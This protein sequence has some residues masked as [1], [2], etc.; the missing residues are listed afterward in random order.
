MRAFRPGDEPAILTLFHR[1]FGRGSPGFQPRTLAHWRWEF[2]GAPMGRRIFVATGAG[3]VIA[4]FA[5]LRFAAVCGDADVCIELGVD[6][7]ADGLGAGL[8]RSRPFVRAARAYFADCEVAGDVHATYGFPN[9]QALRVGRALLGYRRVA[10]RL[11]VL[12][13]RVP[14]GEPA[15]PEPRARD[16]REVARFC[17]NADLLWSQVRGRLGFALVRDARYLNWRWADAPYP[18]RRLEVHGPRGLCAVAV[19]RPDWC[20]APIL[21]IAEYLGDPDDAASLRAVLRHAHALA[22]T[23]GQRRVELL[24]PRRSPLFA[25]AVRAG[26]QVERSR[27][28]LCLRVHTPPAS[29]AWHRER[30]YFTL[31]DSDIF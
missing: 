29:I 20:G 14:A 2:D 6:S 11:P 17:A 25:H 23:E 5:A 16:V 15:A 19:L 8:A 24:L 3:A 26:W 10:T 21:A 4:H 22:R 31:G 12:F 28:R 7:M 13:L 9:D 30:W 1:V 18:Y 27:L